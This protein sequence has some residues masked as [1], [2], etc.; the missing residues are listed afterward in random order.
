VD[1]QNFSLFVV[2]IIFVV[3]VLDFDQVR[4]PFLN[5][6]NQH[7]PEL[8]FG[9]SPCRRHQQSDTCKNDT[10]APASVLSI[11]I[12]FQYGEPQSEGNQPDA[13]MR[14]SFTE[15][16]RITFRK[17]SRLSVPVIFRC[18]LLKKQGS[19]GLIHAN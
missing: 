17:S 7:L 18:V 8:A 4:L 6:S 13:F 12:S 2:V 10:R 9:P 16:N 15:S 3:A 11:P 1:S 19:F 5:N 14:A